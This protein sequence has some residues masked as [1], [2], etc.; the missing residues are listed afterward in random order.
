MGKK[1]KRS[2]RNYYTGPEDG[3]TTLV[4]PF[5]VGDQVVLVSGGPVM[6]VHEVG[7][8]GLVHCVWF[9]TREDGDQS[10]IGEAELHAGAIELVKR[11]PMFQPVVTSG[12]VT[13]ITTTR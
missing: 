9:D 5:G 10:T 11:K 12:A 13:N 1:N 6:T 8:N 4:A 3:T 2:T 7:K